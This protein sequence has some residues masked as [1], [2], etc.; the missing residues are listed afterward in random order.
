MNKFELSCELIQ[1]NDTLIE[2]MVDLDISN[3]ASMLQSINIDFND[4][5]KQTLQINPYCMK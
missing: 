3:Y 1:I 2:C 4:G 5:T